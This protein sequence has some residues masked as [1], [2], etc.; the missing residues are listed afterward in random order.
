MSE[1]NS[2]MLN[3]RSSGPVFRHSTGSYNAA[4]PIAQPKREMPG[5]ICVAPFKTL[6]KPII[7]EST[8]PISSLNLLSTDNIIND[9]RMIYESISCN[10][11]LNDL[12]LPASCLLANGTQKK[13]HTMLR[14]NSSDTKVKETGSI[15]TN[16]TKKKGKDL[17]CR[18]ASLLMVGN[19]LGNTKDQA[20]GDGIGDKIICN[21][22]RIRKPNPKYMETSP[23]S[24]T[25]TAVK[26]S[27][28]SAANSNHNS[29]L[30]KRKLHDISK[31]IGSPDT[32]NSYRFQKTP[33]PNRRYK[34]Q[35][36]ESFASPDASTEVPVLVPIKPEYTITSPMNPSTHFVI[37][38][39]SSL[40]TYVNH[41]YGGNDKTNSDV[42]TTDP[43]VYIR[44]LWK[45]LHD[46]IDTN[47]LSDIS[48]SSNVNGVAPEGNSIEEHHLPLNVHIES[49]STQMHKM[50]TL[51]NFES[52][53]NKMDLAPATPVATN[54]DEKM[55]EFLKF[56]DAK[57]SCGAATIPG[58][59]QELCG[60]IY[61]EEYSSLVPVPKQYQ[62]FLDSESVKLNSITDPGANVSALIEAYQV[63]LDAQSRVI[64]CELNKSL[65]ES[66][67]KNVL[68]ASE[69]ELTC[70]SLQDTISSVY[71]SLCTRRS[72]VGYDWY[73]NQF[74]KAKKIASAKKELDENANASTSLWTTP[75]SS[76]PARETRNRNQ[77]IHEGV[78]LNMYDSLLSVR[79]VKS[80]RNYVEYAD[81][82]EHPK[83]PDDALKRSVYDTLIRMKYFVNNGHFPSNIRS[84]LVMNEGNVVSIDGVELKN[85]MRSVQTKPHMTIQ[86]TNIESEY[87]LKENPFY[88]FVC[89]LKKGSVCDL[90]IDG[91]WVKATVLAIEYSSVVHDQSSDVREPCKFVDFIKVS[92]CK[93]S[94]R[95][96]VA[97]SAPAKD[98]ATTR[99]IK[100]IRIEDVHK[101][102][103]PYA[104]GDKVDAMYLGCGK[105]FPGGIISYN[106]KGTY[107]V[108]YDDNEVEYQIPIDR[109]HKKVKSN[110]KKDYNGDVAKKPILF[111]H[112]I[113][114]CG[115]F[116]H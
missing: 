5:P 76:R 51:E 21:T 78:R 47:I 93:A 27:P 82:V 23:I 4:I 103:Y 77:G 91:C 106:V 10:K 6:P 61:L 97:A 114:P 57:D 58:F 90:Y 81:L 16:I 98:T 22:K 108:Q 67:L 63:E 50:V 19:Q 53:E 48:Q 25:S 30:S 59:V 102:A 24:A 71:T 12:E 20:N 64:E 80:Q 92:Y 8:K 7:V 1:G 49:E 44:E 87:S 31:K 55:N 56:I 73:V 39:C 38:D 109:L 14:R 37:N 18:M 46:A 35:K 100:W 105:W 111:Q 34:K 99:Y 74:K 88:S 104:I 110:K 89:S 72:V 96:T 28:I 79:K 86:P 69:L 75:S 42:I 40:M 66:V 13:K 2:R 70:N 94:S 83:Y 54:V 95:C 116:N 29:N 36:R 43:C 85:I 112:M 9:K 41:V 65:F 113:T 45:T 101:Y 33:S 26:V 3:R 32:S 115:L 11:Y 17:E 15:P 107:D 84:K 62:T 52:N 68:D 60:G